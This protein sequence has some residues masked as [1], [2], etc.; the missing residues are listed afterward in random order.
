M[1]TN[2]H[3]ERARSRTLKATV[4]ACVAALLQARRVASSADACTDVGSSFTC[5]TSFT[6]LDR[7]T[8]TAHM[9]DP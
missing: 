1:V 4:E 6:T 9:A 8:T 2:T 3:A 5:T 7:S